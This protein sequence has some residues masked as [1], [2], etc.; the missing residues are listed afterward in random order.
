MAR[1]LALEK[2]THTGFGKSAIAILQ[3]LTKLRQIANHPALIDED[4][5][6]G[7]GKYDEIIRTIQNLL[8]EGHKALI[9]SSFVKHLELVSQHLDKNRTKYSWLTGETHDREKEIKKFQEDK[10]CP[11]F[12]ISLKA[13]GVGLNLTAAEYVLILDPWWN[14]AAEMQA[15]S[16][17]HRIGQDKHVFVYRFISRNTLEEKILKLHERKSNLADAFINDSL[18]G[19]NPEDVMELFD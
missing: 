6:S 17:A 2:I 14:P 13:G 18:K 10:D 5:F 1:N 9:F 4:Y 8:D 16:R 15:I 11:L 19:I 12:L 7:S 3:S